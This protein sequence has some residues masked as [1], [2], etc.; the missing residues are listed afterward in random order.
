MLYTYGYT[1]GSMEDLKAFTEA[2]A[3][4]LDIRYSTNSRVAHWR[5]DALRLA[6]KPNYEHVRDFG[7][8]N[9][10]EDADIELV[11]AERGLKNLR[12]AMNVYSDV[13]LLCACKNVDSCH[14]LTV[15]EMA[16]E[17]GIVNVV[18]HL[19]PGDRIE[20]KAKSNG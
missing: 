11:N 1:G 15:A 12:L 8:I 20:R 18:T 16:I 9:Y 4:I 3:L 19:S 2:S 14:R 6:L 13:V 7:N 10:R 5:G 17:D